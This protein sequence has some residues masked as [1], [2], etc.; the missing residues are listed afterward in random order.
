LCAFFSLVVPGQVL[1]LCVLGPLSRA[2]WCFN[3]CFP[4]C[5]TIDTTPNMQHI[6]RPEPH[7][8]VFFTPWPVVRNH[9]PTGMALCANAHDSLTSDRSSRISRRTT[10]LPS[11]GGGAGKGSGD[12]AVERMRSTVTEMEAAVVADSSVAVRRGG[13]IDAAHH[14]QGRGDHG[15]AS[16][17]D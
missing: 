9:P 1:H 4:V 15:E 6:C 7:S 16:H 5:S 14:H 12:E 3:R 8:S 11:G 17:E 10:S 2:L 13:D